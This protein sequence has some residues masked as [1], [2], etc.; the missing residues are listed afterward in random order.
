M[1]LLSAGCED[2]LTAGY[3]IICGVFA[4]TIGL[5]NGN[6]LGRRK[7]QFSACNFVVIVVVDYI[8]ILFSKRIYIY[9]YSSRATTISFYYSQRI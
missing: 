2:F 5:L 1:G 8:F 6:R 4:A 9:T 3:I 7:L